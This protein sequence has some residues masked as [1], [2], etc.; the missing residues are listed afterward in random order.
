MYVLFMI[1][2]NQG[3][4]AVRHNDAEDNLPCEVGAQ[5]SCTHLPFRNRRRTSRGR[6]FAP[7]YCGLQGTLVA[8]GMHG[9]KQ[10]FAVAFWTD[11]AN[12]AFCEHAA[13]SWATIRPVQ[14]T[15]MYAP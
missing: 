8:V 2:L 10:P 3:V 9:R 7:Q 14:F 12:I 4:F 13:Q 11:E 5:V 1:Q 6:S 15:A